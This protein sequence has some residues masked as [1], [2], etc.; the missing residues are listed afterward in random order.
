MRKVLSLTISL[1]LFGAGAWARWNFT[2]DAGEGGSL[3]KISTSSWLVG[4]TPDPAAPYDTDSYP[5]LDDVFYTGGS[6]T[7]IQKPQG[8]QA[9]QCETSY[10]PKPAISSG[11]QDNPFASR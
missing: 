3:S 9:S 7:V 4:K 10:Q 11:V 2:R 1:L 6:P 5:A 8:C